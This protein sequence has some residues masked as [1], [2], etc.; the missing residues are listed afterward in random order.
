ML[1]IHGLFFIHNMTICYTQDS[2][3]KHPEFNLPCIYNVNI[4]VAMVAG[5]VEKSNAMSCEMLDQC[6]YEHIVWTV[7]AEFPGENVT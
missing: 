5:L 6:D 1:I 3:Y 2:G 4:S 7:A